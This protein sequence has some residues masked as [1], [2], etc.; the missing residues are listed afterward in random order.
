M[1]FW[2]PSGT[3]KTTLARIVASEVEADFIEIVQLHRGIADVKNILYE[4]NKINS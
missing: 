4:L 1:I 3:G 2:G